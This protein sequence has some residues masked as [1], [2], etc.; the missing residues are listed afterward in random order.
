MRVSGAFSRCDTGEG[1]Q[2][3]EVAATPGTM[4]V[5]DSKLTAGPILRVS[6]RAWA[7]FVGLAA[8]E[9]GPPDSPDGGPHTGVTP[10]R[11]PPTCTPG[12]KRHGVT[13]PRS[14]P[15]RP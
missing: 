2:C 12:P 15:G 11:P 5:R 10:P 1:G 13:R 9:W 8:T 6:P 7:G 14:G 4:H 3:V